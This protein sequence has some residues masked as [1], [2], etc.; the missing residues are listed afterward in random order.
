MVYV[1]ACNAADNRPQEE[2]LQHANML[3]VCAS[4]IV[5]RAN[6]IL[7]HAEGKAISNIRGY[8]T[9]MYPYI[10]FCICTYTTYTQDFELNLAL[11]EGQKF[12]FAVLRDEISVR[13]YVV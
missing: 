5:V 7:L 10:Q 1:C 9:R 12:Y 13:L 2:R 8:Y 6:G 4:I 11:Y 3:I